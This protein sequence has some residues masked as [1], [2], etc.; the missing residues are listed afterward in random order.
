MVNQRTEVRCSACHAVVA[1]TAQHCRLCGE[2]FG[3]P[4][5]P[6]PECGAK[7]LPGDLFC[8]KC[9]S[10]LPE[11]TLHVHKVTVQVEEPYRLRGLAIALYCAIS[12]CGWASVWRIWSLFA[13]ID[14]VRTSQAALGG[15]ESFASAQTNLFYENM[16]NA[17]AEV[18]AA[19]ALHTWSWLLVLAILITWLWRATKNLKPRSAVKWGPGWAIGGW[20]TPIGFFFIPY[21]VVR[22]AWHLKRAPDGSMPNQSLQIWLPTWIASWIALL[23]IGAA[24]EIAP[25]SLQ[26]NPN[27]W[28]NW[29]WLQLWSADLVQALGSALL[30]VFL[31]GLAFTVRR[32]SARHD[33]L[34][35]Q[36]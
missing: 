5:C 19:I 8:D 7:H 3:E 2:S 34:E 24:P 23:A 4:S 20:F 17:D 32:I 10:L 26:R 22:D 12:L 35:M 25:Q 6:N 36:V 13:R 28:A 9:G 15:P 27:S 31:V 1:H 21:Q 14:V 30:I 18:G 33:G 29:E 16:E 11:E